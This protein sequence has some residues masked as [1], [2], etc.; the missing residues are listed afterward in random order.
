MKLILVTLLLMF[1]I[2][3]ADTGAPDKDSLSYL[4]V[5]EDFPQAFC[6]ALNIYYE[7]RSDNLAGQFAVADVVINRSL[8]RRYPN[9]ICTVVK[10]GSMKSGKIYGTYV[11]DGVTIRYPSCQFSWYCDGKSD[12]PTESLQW[13]K[14]QAVAYRLLFK[15][16]H[17]GITEGATHYHAT[18]V[19]PRWSQGLQ[20]VGQIGAHI[21][22]RWP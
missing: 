18:Y 15:Q 19:D 9:T 16:Q 7:A 8:D 11:R 3:H 1:G 14:A 2:A 21:F 10:Q 5:E 22:Y 12:V 20:Q 4:Y 6:L 13:R 17:R